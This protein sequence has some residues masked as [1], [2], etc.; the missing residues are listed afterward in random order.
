M[1]VV[2]VKCRNTVSRIFFLVLDLTSN[3]NFWL[4]ELSFF[5]KKKGTVTTFLLLRIQDGDSS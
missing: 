3:A 5:S 1:L 2:L 4:M